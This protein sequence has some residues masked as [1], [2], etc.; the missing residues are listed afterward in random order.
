MRISDWSSDVCSSD[1][2]WINDALMA[3]FF[4]LV[5]LEIKREFMDGRL[6]T[7]ERRRLP[8]IAAGAGMALPALVYL[9]VTRGTPGLHAGWAIPAATDIAFA[10]GV[11]A[12][13]GS[14]APTSLKLFLT[15]VAIVDDMGAVAIIALAYTD[16]ISTIALGGAALVLG[17]L[18][19]LGKSGV[20][21][22]PVYAI[23]VDRKSTRLNSSH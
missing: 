1:L 4:L 7:W 2:L 5:G 15:T 10:I 8:V 12:L 11:L 13:L 16:Q 18:Y 23:G 17:L 3:L 9:T 20:R 22:L 21:A 6:S 14:R 19:V